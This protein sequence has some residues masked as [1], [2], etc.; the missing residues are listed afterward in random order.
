MGDDENIF[1]GKNDFRDHKKKHRGELKRYRMVWER[2]E[3]ETCLYFSSSRSFFKNVSGLIVVGG[4]RERYLYRT[5]CE[6]M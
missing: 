4:W 1:H 2:G 5:S 3:G 6:D